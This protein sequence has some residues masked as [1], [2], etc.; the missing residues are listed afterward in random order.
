MK[1]NHFLKI[2][3]LYTPFLN[4]C[5]DSFLIRAESGKYYHRLDIPEFIFLVITEM[6]L[7]YILIRL[8]KR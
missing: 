7:L 1:C 3:Y 6:V 8:M 5:S 2:L 4:G